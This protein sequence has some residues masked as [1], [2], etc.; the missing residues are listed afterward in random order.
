MNGRIDKDGKLL[1]ERKGKLIAQDCKFS[2]NRE[3]EINGQCSHFCPLFSEPTTN[4]GKIILKLCHGKV[5][6]F[7][8]LVDKRNSKEK[9]DV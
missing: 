1:I 8:S 6:K 5:L 3:Y 4:N 2:S 7:D 9:N